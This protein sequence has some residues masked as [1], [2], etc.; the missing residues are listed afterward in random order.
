L[1]IR[2]LLSTS[3]ASVFLEQPLS[4]NIEEKI[5]ARV[6]HMP[7]CVT[8]R[9]IELCNMFLRIFRSFSLS[10]SLQSQLHKALNFSPVVLSYL[11]RPVSAGFCDINRVYCRA[12]DEVLQDKCGW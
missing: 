10:W 1:R 8:W 11:I 4:K 2:P 9:N 6:S 5:K 12:K 3:S 7:E